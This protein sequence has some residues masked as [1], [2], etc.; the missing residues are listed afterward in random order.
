MLRKVGCKH[1]I[2][3]YIPIGTW[4][5]TASDECIS[6]VKSVMAGWLPYIIVSSSYVKQIPSG[7]SHQ[8]VTAASV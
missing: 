2:S 6:K 8:K 5:E 4:Y 7:N 3:Y 1:C